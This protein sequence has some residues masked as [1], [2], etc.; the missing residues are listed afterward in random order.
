MRR[1][2]FYAALFATAEGS[3]KLF[4]IGTRVRT[5]SLV[6]GL[7]C[8]ATMETRE[9]SRAIMSFDTTS[10]ILQRS[11]KPWLY[12]GT[13][14]GWSADDI[15]ISTVVIAD[16]MP[17]FHRGIQ[18]KHKVQQGLLASIACRYRVLFTRCLIDSST[19]IQ[20]AKRISLG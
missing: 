16:P 5:T 11:H 7:I 17:G 13:L 9:Y 3:R 12:G 15:E 1:T 4:I 6:S 2:L 8:I 10:V 14:K 18:L 20:E 19:H